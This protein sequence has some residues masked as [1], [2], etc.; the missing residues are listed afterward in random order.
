[1]KFGPFAGGMS[2][3]IWRNT[4]ETDNWPRD[5]GSI[6]I[7][8]RR[9][10]DTQ[11]WEWNDDSFRQCDLSVVILALQS[12]QQYVSLHALPHHAA[13]E[14]RFSGQRGDVRPITCE[15]IR[16]IEVGPQ[17]FGR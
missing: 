12:G 3:A 14:V 6:T 13:S 1:M 11:T 5:V 10:K 15:K 2:V 9:L 16:R 17:V 8:A 7:N 4:I